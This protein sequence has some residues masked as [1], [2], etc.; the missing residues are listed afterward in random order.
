MR[1]LMV[2]CHDDMVAVGS[3]GTTDFSSEST[4]EY[5]IG[6]EWMDMRY[7]FFRYYGA[8]GGIHETSL[9]V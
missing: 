8:D 7:V 3:G 2:L 9:Y 5:N 1:D 4:R 6:G